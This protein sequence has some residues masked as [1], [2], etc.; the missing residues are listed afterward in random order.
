MAEMEV[1]MHYSKKR[2][3][4]V[5]KKMMPPNNKSIPQISREEGIPESTLYTWRTKAREAGV[6]LPAGSNT[7]AG[8]SSKDKFFAVLETAS[9][10]EAEISIYCRKKGLYPEQIQNWKAACEKANDW[11]KYSS[12]QFEHAVKKEKQ[13]NKQLARELYR[14]EKALAETAALLVLRKKAQAI[15]GTG[16]EE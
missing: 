10:S 2:K 15:W 3:E 8:W 11:D 6:L 13:K 5:L 9:L 7:P 4:T 14:K 16:E 12:Q 1:L